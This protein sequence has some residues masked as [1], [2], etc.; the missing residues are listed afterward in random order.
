[1]AVEAELLT[2]GNDQLVHMFQLV[3]PSGIPE[4]DKEDRIALRIDQAVEPPFESFNIWEFWHKGI[5]IR[6]PGRQEQTDK[7]LNLT[8]RLDDKWEVFKDLKQWQEMNFNTS[9][10]TA[11]PSA[12]LRNKI[13]IECYDVNFK[14][15]Y[16][17]IY[18]GCYLTGL[19]IGTFDPASGEPLRLILTIIYNDVEY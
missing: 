2:L 12:L 17:I 8:I 3:F 1:M 6:K 10:A 15:V 7:T 9:N 19:K 14:N 4:S 5:K 16:S 13:A 18:S 11:L